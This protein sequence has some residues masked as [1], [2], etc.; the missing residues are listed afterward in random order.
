MKYASISSI[1]LGNENPSFGEVMQKVSDDTLKALGTSAKLVQFI[2]KSSANAAMNAGKFGVNY[3][4]RSLE[5][6][7]LN[8]TEMALIQ[9]KK[10]MIEGVFGVK[11]KA[12]RSMAGFWQKSVDG[13]H[14]ALETVHNG[15]NAVHNGI[16]SGK[17]LILLKKYPLFRK[18]MFNSNIGMDRLKLLIELKKF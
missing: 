9:K 4:H 11:R 15:F 12:M 8:R 14:S 3:A 6:S 10:A 17:V 1:I 5:E 7:A 16:H 13:I 18:I 2:G